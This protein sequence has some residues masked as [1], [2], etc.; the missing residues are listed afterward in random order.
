MSLLKIEK[1]GGL[2]L[3]MYLGGSKLASGPGFGGGGFD[4]TLLDQ[5]T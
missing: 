5:V 3:P 2:V 4:P 1:D